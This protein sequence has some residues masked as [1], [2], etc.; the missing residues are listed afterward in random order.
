MLEQPAFGVRLR[1]LRLERGLSQAALAKGVMSTG[2]LSR[3]ESGARPPTERMV[4]HLAERL[5]VPLSAFDS[6]HPTA[7][8]LAQVLA[9][10][11]SAEQGD[12]MADKLADALC[13]DEPFDPALRWQGLWLL[14]RMREHQARYSD[15]HD[16]LAEL[17]ALSDEL[18]SPELRTRARVQ[19]ARCLRIL[20]HLAEAVDLADEANRMAGELPVRDR[21]SAL[22]ALISAETEAGRLVQARAHADELC[23]IT[24][25]LG[26]TVFVEA[27]WASATVRMRQG[28]HAGAEAA[29]ERALAGLAGHE[30]LTLWTRLRLAAASLYLQASPPLT[31]KARATLDEVAPVI[32][33]VGTE[34][35]EQQLLSLRGQLAFEEGDLATAEELSGR[36]DAQRTLLSF[37]DRLRFESLRGQLLI[38]RGRVDEGAQL[39]QD[40]GQQAEESG[41]IELAAQIW[42]G[43]AR[44]LASTRTTRRKPRK[45][46]R[47]PEVVNG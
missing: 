26:G 12:D 23:A 5:G 25:P 21:A 33:L 10:V 16:L 36:I 20:G 13:A 7:A 32:D 8:S 2:Y 45:Q 35:H 4:A 15:E 41:N 40:L 37:R 11:T 27:L 19:M 9:T 46:T 3:L 31:A 6:S 22:S 30:S 29:L 14:S 24:E 28:D 47:N 34:L 39:L 17:I 42:R 43:L 44:I 18:G 1:A 38:A